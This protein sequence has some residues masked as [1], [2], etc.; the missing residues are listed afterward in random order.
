M[1]SRSICTF[2]LAVGLGVSAAR[3]GEELADRLSKN[4]TL[5][6]RIQTLLP[7]GISLQAAAAGFR[8]E[9]EFITA[10]H[11][12]RNLNIPFNELKADLMGP[13]HHTLT[14]ALHDLRPELRTS[15]INR[16]M[17]RATQQARTDFQQAGE[18]AENSATE[19]P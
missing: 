9:A 6:A 3:P 19:R 10:L 16:Q 13:K 12:S 2:T 11:V 5:S 1:N 18:L 7:P 17:K 4:P 8:D 15:G 14:G